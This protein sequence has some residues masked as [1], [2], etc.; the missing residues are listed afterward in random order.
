MMMLK[1][2]MVLKFT[3]TETYILASFRKIK[4][5]EKDNFIGLVYLHKF[6]SNLLLYST[7]MATGGEVYQMVRVHIKKP[8]VI[9]T[10]D[11][12]KTV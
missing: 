3:Q 12:S 8:T 4:S 5:M 10:M 6:I 1:L 9:F 11:S 7:T 2:A